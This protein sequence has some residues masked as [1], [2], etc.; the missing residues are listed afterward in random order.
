MKSWKDECWNWP[1]GTKKALLDRDGKGC[2]MCFSQQGLCIHHYYESFDSPTQNYPYYNM[3]T[4]MPNFDLKDLVLLCRSCHGKVHCT[5]YKSPFML[6]FHQLMEKVRK[7]E[8]K[9]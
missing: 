8:V 2:V 9:S 4:K 6:T 5:S 1:R 3:E 7:I